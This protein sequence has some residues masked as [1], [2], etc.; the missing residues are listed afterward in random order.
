MINPSVLLNAKK[1]MDEAT[2]TMSKNDSDMAHGAFKDASKAFWND[3]EFRSSLLSM[4]P[5]K[6]MA[7]PTVKG[8]AEKYNFDMN[9]NKDLIKSF[10]PVSLDDILKN[11]DLVNSFSPMTNFLDTINPGENFQQNNF[12]SSKSN[13]FKK[14]SNLIP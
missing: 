9:M 14:K 7:N 8:M 11:K 12:L 1:A 10:K 6:L 2:K 3:K 5:E 4:D 13:P